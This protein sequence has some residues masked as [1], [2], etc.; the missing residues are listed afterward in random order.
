MKKNVPQKSLDKNSNVKEISDG[1][2][3]NL[4]RITTEEDAFEKAIEESFK[5]LEEDETSKKD[6]KNSKD[7]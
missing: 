2:Y 7:I 3:I 4:N 6:R 5:E 1:V